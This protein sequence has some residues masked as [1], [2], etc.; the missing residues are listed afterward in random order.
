MGKGVAGLYVSTHPLDDFRNY[1]KQQTQSLKKFDK[2]DDGRSIKLGG[3][4]TAL[5]KIYTR[6]ND[7]M[8]F[9]QLET[10]DGDVEVI[11]FPRTYQKYE[12]LWML[13][14]VIEIEGKINARDR[15]GAPTDDLKIMADKVKIL[16][17]EIA[18]KW[19][20]PKE[21]ETLSSIEI[22]LDSITD[23]TSLMQIKGL[24]DGYP[25]DAIV[26][27]EFVKTGQKLKLP[28]GA[29]G[30]EKLIDGLI[31]IAGSGNI[32]TKKAEKHPA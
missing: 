14:N 27:L 23:E 1:L 29:N 21:P 11:V 28:T 15:E 30:D 17:A 18:R 2:S 16:N 20:P 19:L 26:T 6:N 7:P 25:G 5:R 22:K 10:I 8:A 4:I 12:E 24:L 13:D 3:I 32:I 31:K 9:V